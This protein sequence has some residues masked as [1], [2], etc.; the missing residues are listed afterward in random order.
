MEWSLDG[1]DPQPGPVNVDA[2]GTHVV[3]TRAVDLAG[4]VSAW[5]STTVHVDVSAPQNT[6]PAADGAWRTTPYA[7]TVAA[8]D[9]AGS[10]VST[11]QWRLGPDGEITPSADA[12]VDAEGET[13]LQTRAVDAVGH[14]SD[15]RSETIRLDRV[16]PV[17][18]LDCG[19]ADW[20]TTAA[21]CVPAADGGPSGLASL[22]VAGQ[23]A[24][25]GA[26]V[27]V[28]GDGERTIT[29]VAV[30][31]A[32]N[33]SEVS[34]VVRVD[35]TP[36]VA[37]L[38]CAPTG[39]PTGYR[40]VARATDAGAGVGLL[41]WR[42]GGGAWTAPAANGSFAVGSGRVEVRAVDH[43]GLVTVSAPTVLAERRRIRTRQRTVP[44]SLRGTKGSAGLLGSLE[45]RVVRDS[46]GQATAVADL[47]PLGVGN[48]RYRTTLTLR[49]GGLRAERRRAFR[50][51][52]GGVTPRL[53]LALSRVKRPAQVTLL[54]ERRKGKR[55]VRV[56]TAVAAVKPPT[57]AG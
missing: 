8:D 27:P 39:V 54:L 15:W 20:R 53:G 11:V 25:S 4:N 9:G 14:A 50:L 45:L 38:A 16:A 30:D 3:R 57:Q 46:A 33:R 1:A 21:S 31:G 41:Q 55:W 2:D 52:H 17:L 47:R 13:V 28:A 26:T 44:V 32:G 43:A 22:T 40:C 24:A 49:S 6:T 42:V 29:A 19:S 23:A 48:G 12:L 10:G 5:R 34:R 51:G 36:P 35:R 37:A 56:A 7:V 18:S